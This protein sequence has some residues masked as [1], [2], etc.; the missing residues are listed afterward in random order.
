MPEPAPTPQ[1]NYD[2]FLN[3]PPKSK[4]PL[5]KLNTGSLKMRLIIVAGGLLVL[6]II[7]IIVSSL[8]G[9]GNKSTPFIAVAQDQNE[10][11]R[12]ATEAN[13]QTTVQTTANLDQNVELSLTSAQQQ[14]LE[15]LHTNGSKISTKQLIATVN[16]KTDQA[17]AAAT[18]VSNFDAVFAQVMQT[19]LQSY[20]HDLKVATLTT[21][22]NSKILLNND[23]N[24]ATLL[25]AQANTTV[26]S[27]QNQ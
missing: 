7:I 17:L 6:I 10:L 11:V 5:L 4:L 16:T 3:P 23:I 2:F 25:L 24:S 1:V 15:Y 8:L 27:L 22:P 26:S 13:G 12:V 20:I 21:G 18:A 19:G 14:L 9:G